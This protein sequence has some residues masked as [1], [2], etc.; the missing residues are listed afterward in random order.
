MRSLVALLAA[1]SGQPAMQRYLAPRRARPILDTVLHYTLT[2]S[3]NDI[4][5]VFPLLT[6]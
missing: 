4:A 2:L 5:P 3:Q 1:I 6:W